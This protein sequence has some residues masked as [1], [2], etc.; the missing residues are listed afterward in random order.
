MQ[1]VVAEFNG[2]TQH[3]IVWL[4]GNVLIFWVLVFLT[5]SLKQE[6]QHLAFEAHFNQSIATDQN[7]RYL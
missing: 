6:G 3:L 7:Y 1:I 5:I 4:I 2:L